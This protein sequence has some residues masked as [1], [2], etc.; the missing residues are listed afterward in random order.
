MAKCVPEF[1]K[2]GIYPLYPAIVNEEDSISGEVPS[3]DCDY[4]S[5][6]I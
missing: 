4:G 6:W 2:T 5:G 3:S 1:A